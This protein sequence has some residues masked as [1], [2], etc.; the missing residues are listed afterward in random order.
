LEATGYI[1]CMHAHNTH[2][3]HTRACAHAH[4]Q[5]ATY[6]TYYISYSSLVV[7]VELVLGRND[8]QHGKANQWISAI[9]E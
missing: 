7:S 8:Y 6:F 1:V 2:Y 4:T 3:T 5:Y 9:V